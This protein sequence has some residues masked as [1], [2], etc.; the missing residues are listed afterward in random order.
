MGAP[1]IPSPSALFAS[2]LEGMKFRPLD[3]YLASTLPLLPLTVGA[4]AVGLGFLGDVSGLF[5]LLGMRN[6]PAFQRV[7]INGVVTRRLVRTVL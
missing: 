2:G 3:A 5:H 4:G 1:P 7:T 6:R